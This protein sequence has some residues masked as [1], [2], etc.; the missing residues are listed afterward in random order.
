MGSIQSQVIGGGPVG[1]NS[2]NPRDRLVAIGRGDAVH[3]S[4]TAALELVDLAIE[5]R[6]TEMFRR[7]LDSGK[8]ETDDVSSVAV[9]LAAHELRAAARLGRLE[10]AA[11]PV[12]KRLIEHGCDVMVAKGWWAS[13]MLYE[14]PSDR[15]F[16]DVDLVI[17]PGWEARKAEIDEVLGPP[18]AHGRSVRAA[19]DSLGWWTY[20]LPGITVDIHRNPFTLEHALAPE[21]EHMWCAHTVAG[22]DRWGGALAPSLELGMAQL[23]V[24]YGKDRLRWLYQLDDLRRLMVRPDVNWPK[25]WELVEVGGV[26]RPVTAVLAAVIRL[27]E[28]DPPPGLGRPSLLMNPWVGSRRIL[29]GRAPTAPTISTAAYR[30]LSGGRLRDGLRTASSV[31]LPG[32]EALISHVEVESP[33]AQSGYGHGLGALYWHRLKRLAGAIPPPA[34]GTPAAPVWFLSETPARPSAPPGR[35]GDPA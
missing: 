28:V 15:I 11:V 3:V 17:P 4:P 14:R 7:A 5:H 20:D 26:N 24:N 29:S 18:R 35:D 9:A 21:S 16:S 27:F 23:A 1:S 32:R 22:D 12:V 19:A 25:F 30:A 33:A 8:V 2:V 6:V 13:H 34:A 10:A 31:I